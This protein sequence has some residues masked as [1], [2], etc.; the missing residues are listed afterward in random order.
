MQNLFAASFFRNHDL[1]ITY[2]KHFKLS[3][4]TCI[5]LRTIKA[6]LKLNPR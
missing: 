6:Y 4:A 1:F 3:L 2:I 5:T